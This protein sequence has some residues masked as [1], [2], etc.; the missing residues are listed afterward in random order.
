MGTNNYKITKEIPN[1]CPLFGTFVRL[2]ENF[3]TKLEKMVASV[4]N[5]HIFSLGV[6]TEH[7]D[8]TDT[9]IIYLI[10]TDHKILINIIIFKL[11]I[12]Y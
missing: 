3:V 11:S 9:D 12:E 5:G 2:S 1:K 7:I 10:K 6:T 4:S 8:R